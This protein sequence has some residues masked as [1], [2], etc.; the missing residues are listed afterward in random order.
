MRIKQTDDIHCGSILV[1][2]NEDVLI[3]TQRIENMVSGISYKADG[4]T[5]TIVTI[6]LPEYSS[7]I[8]TIWSHISDIPRIKGTADD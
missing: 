2:K 5:L 7:Q 3:V 6:S 1:L 8:K 4:V